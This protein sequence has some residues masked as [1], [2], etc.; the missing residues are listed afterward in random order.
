MQ[1]RHNASIPRSRLFLS[2]LT[3][4]CRVP[5]YGMWPRWC[6]RWISNYLKAARWRASWDQWFVVVIS[7]MHT[8]EMKVIHRTKL[9]MHWVC[10][11]CSVKCPNQL[12][13]NFPFISG[14]EAQDIGQVQPTFDRKAVCGSHHHWKGVFF[15]FFFFC[16]FF[17]T[18][19]IQLPHSTTNTSWQM[20]LLKISSGEGEPKSPLVFLGVSV[21]ADN[22]MPCTIMANYLALN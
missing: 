18:A 12:I 13:D 11:T 9:S 7:W 21:T 16:F 20:D 4:A 8:T 10:L 5:G 3:G 17:F 14:R 6:S 2:L 15:C 22:L 1:V 19:I